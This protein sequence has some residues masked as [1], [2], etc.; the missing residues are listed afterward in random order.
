M[1]RPP[2]PLEALPPEAALLLLLVPGT[3][4]FEVGEFTGLVM[5]CS[6]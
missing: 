4:L 3:G 5:G 1:V 2:T 6:Y